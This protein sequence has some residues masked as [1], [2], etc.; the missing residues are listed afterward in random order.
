M[1]LFN[2]LRY[3]ENILER[4]LT[5]VI[6]QT[7]KSNLIKLICLDDGSTDETLNFLKM[8]QSKHTL[9]RHSHDKV[10]IRIISRA[11]KGLINTIL[12]LISYVDTD[13]FTILESDDYLEKN[14]IEN[15]LSFSENGIIDV[16]STK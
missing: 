14:A 2:S 1:P 4:A 12:E 15:F 9:G 3:G 10:E 6:N 8:F 7:Y 11:N 16:I 5:S 13:Y